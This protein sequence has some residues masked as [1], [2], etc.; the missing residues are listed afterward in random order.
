MIFHGFV[1]TAIDLAMMHIQMLQN[2]FELLINSAILLSNPAINPADIWNVTYSAGS[3]SYWVARSFIGTGGALD[4][5]RQNAT[6][7]SYI[8]DA[9]NYIGMNATR[10]FGDPEGS[11]GMSAVL[12]NMTTV[13][14]EN[15]VT[16]F[17][18]AMIENVKLAY[19]LLSNVNVTMR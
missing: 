11:R 3:F 8:A 17:T 12:K 5:A 15:F 19:K 13:I 4:W 2:T 18:R 9:T 7:M 16:Q 1:V 6:A 14:D 10:I